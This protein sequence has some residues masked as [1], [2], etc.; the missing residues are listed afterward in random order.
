[1]PEYVV[2][3]ICGS[4]ESETVL[5][6]RDIWLG[7]PGE[8][9]LVKCARCGLH[10][11]NPRPTAEELGSFYPTTYYS[12]RDKKPETDKSWRK[13]LSQKIKDRRDLSGMPRGMPGMRALDVGCGAGSFLSVMEAHGW[14]AYGVEPFEGGRLARERGL[15]VHHGTVEDAAYPDGFFHFIR[16]R[17]V[18]EHIPAPKK[19]L[20]S[21]SRILA[22]EGSIQIIVPNHGGLNARLF[23]KYWESLDLPRHLYHFGARDIRRLASEVGLAV[24]KVTYRRSH[25]KSSMRY[26]LADRSDSHIRPLAL[27]AGAMAWL[28]HFVSRTPLGDEMTIWLSLARNSD[29]RSRGF[30]ALRLGR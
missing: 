18:L 1:M 25:F 19:M 17:H 13:R 9:R 5:T 30:N 27:L 10:Y 4:A 24:G 23:G 14:E 20:S 26:L 28:L 16:L 22:P 8:F 12:F 21:L 11:V 7:K 15:R 2:C 3:D 6:G 29:L